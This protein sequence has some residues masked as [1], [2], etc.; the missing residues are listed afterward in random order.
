MN[1]T[2]LLDKQKWDYLEQIHKETT[3]QFL[4]SAAAIPTTGSSA[5]YFA[6]RQA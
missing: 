3:S 5:K 4:I 1:K 2:D 6:Y